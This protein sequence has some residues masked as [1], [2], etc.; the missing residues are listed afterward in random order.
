[1]SVSSASFPN[2]S[3]SPDTREYASSMNR[4]PPKACCTTAL[5]F[6]AVCPEYPATSVE[7][8]AS[9]R[10]PRRSTPSDLKRF[11]T[12][13]ATVV[14]PVPG[15]PAKI[16]CKTPPPVEGSPAA[17]RSFSTESCALSENINCFTL[18]NPTMLSN[19]SMAQSASSCI[20]RT[21]VQSPVPIVLS[22]LHTPRK[23]PLSKIVS[24][25]LPKVLSEKTRAVWR[26]MACSSNDRARC[27]FLRVG[28]AHLAASITV[29]SKIESH[30][31]PGAI[32]N[33]LSLAIASIK[34][35]ISEEVN[36]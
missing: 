25:S 17:T 27:A 22:G 35:M 8:S 31:S 33:P 19:D 10:C 16:M 18:D 1:M 12:I 9:R 26:S 14:L 2:E 4:T 5:V 24:E 32:V 20:H 29:C 15:F 30:F 3:L 23:S 6:R 36:S 13:R 28:S 21:E 34:L 11:A 7:R